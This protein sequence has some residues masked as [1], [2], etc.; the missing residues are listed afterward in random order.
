MGP[1]R[2]LANLARFEIDGEQ[3]E[4]VFAAEAEAAESGLS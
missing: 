4:P 2:R 1:G 3:A